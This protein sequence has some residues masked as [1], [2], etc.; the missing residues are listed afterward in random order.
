MRKRLLSLLAAVTLIVSAC[1]V[2]PPVQPSPEPDPTL[3]PTFTPL[4]L[5]RPVPTA[6]LLVDPKQERH[7]ETPVASTAPTPSAT[8]SSQPAHVSD[9]PAPD[10]DSPKKVN[11]KKVKCVALTFDDGP[12]IYT[13]QILAT[14]KAKD[15]KATFFMWGKMVSNS[16]KIAKQVAKE[17]HEI[18]N[19]A[20]SHRLLNKL[21]SAEI[22][23]EITRSADMIYKHTGVKT[24]LF[25]PPY[26][27]FN[28]NVTASAQK[29][30]N[31]MVLWDV[32]TVDWKTKRTAKT[33][34]S[35]VNDSKRGSIILVHDVY[36][37]T[38]D[39]VA[40][41]IDGLHDKGFTF[42]TVSELIG[43][44]SPGEKYFKG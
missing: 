29:T 20:W 31:S 21:G 28:A 19:H 1:A 41:I 16:P 27:A 36:A 3:V 6:A 17:G 18:G 12:S 38:A 25:R 42:V 43:K 39:A 9:T 10:A 26:G 44:P 37:T 22:N 32:D 15:V 2:A 11:C 30:G 7:D 35:A 24:N 33:V 13:K 8:A 23:R 4:L 14:L 5:P 34:K 40:G